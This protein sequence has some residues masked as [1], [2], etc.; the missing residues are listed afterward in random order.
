MSESEFTVFLNLLNFCSKC[1][2]HI[3]FFELINCRVNLKFF[4]TN[5]HF[6]TENPQKRF[7]VYFKGRVQ[8]SIAQ[9]ALHVNL[10]DGRVLSDTT[11]IIRIVPN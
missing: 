9:F 5:Y 1:K 6:T 11:S 10:S 2:S 8:H 7:K 4:K 3:L